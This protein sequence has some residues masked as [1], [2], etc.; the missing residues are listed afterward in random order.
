MPK[1]PL[2]SGFGWS[3]RP[4][5]NRHH[6]FDGLKLPQV[7][8]IYP[9]PDF[10]RVARRVLDLLDESSSVEARMLRSELTVAL[11]CRAEMTPSACLTGAITLHRAENPWLTWRRAFSWRRSAT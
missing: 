6:Q 2:T 11:S 7:Q 9:I 5:S 1:V 8:G 4:G 3:G 10:P